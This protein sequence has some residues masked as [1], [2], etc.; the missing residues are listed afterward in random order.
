[1]GN[2]STVKTIR[3]NK[4]DDVEKELLEYAMSKTNFSGYIKRLIQADKFTN[5]AVERMDFKY[6]EDDFKI[7]L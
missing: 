5:G 6:N 3:F 7:E 1:M 4:D 2:N